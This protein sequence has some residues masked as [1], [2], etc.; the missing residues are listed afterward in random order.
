MCFVARRRS[1]QE[2]HVMRWQA[3]ASIAAPTGIF[4]RLSGPLPAP[5]AFFGKGFFAAF[6]PS[7]QNVG[8]VY[9][10][11][12]RTIPT[13]SRR[14]DDRRRRAAYEQ[15]RSARSIDAESRLLIERVVLIFYKPIT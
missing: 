5:V 7:P 14:R 13:P 8:I 3:R 6:I 1:H 15:L 12:P 4:P 9:R 11:L 10:P 2:R